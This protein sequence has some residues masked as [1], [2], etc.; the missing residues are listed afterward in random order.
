MVTKSQGCPQACT[1][2]QERAINSTAPSSS[3]FEKAPI[4]SRLLSWLWGRGEA[5]RSRW[6]DV[7][8]VGD[9]KGCHVTQLP[10]LKMLSEG[11]RNTF[12]L[13]FRDAASGGYTQYCWAFSSLSFRF[14]DLDAVKTPEWH[15]NSAFALAANLRPA[16]LKRIPHALQRDCN[17]YMIK[18]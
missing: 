8:G 13:R 5:W 10:P 9:R 4:C 1:K 15:C 18:G 14:P 11:R 7:W 6:W 3:S 17:T 16:F 2:P 12:L